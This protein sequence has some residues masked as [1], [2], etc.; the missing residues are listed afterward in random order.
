MIG[1]S[2]ILIAATGGAA[3]PILVAAG[4]GMGVVQAGGA[5]YKII[6]AKD[7]DDIEKA[8]YDVGA[9]TST[10]GLSLSGAK[11]SLKRASIE[12]EGLNA[13]SSAKKCITSIKDMSIEG[14]NVIKSGYYRATLRNPFRA[15]SEPAS[16]RKYSKELYKEGVKDAEILFKAIKDVLPEELQDSF[17]GRNKCQRSIYAKMVKER[18][19]MID[20]MIQKVKNNSAFSDAVKKAEIESL[21]ADR[22]RIKIDG[23]FAKSKVE[24]LFG[25]RL[26]LDDVSPA[27]MDKLVSSLCEAVKKGDIE[28]TEI[29]N[30]HGF[31]ENRKGL[32]DAYFSD[33]QIEKLQKASGG[34]DIIRNESKASGYT[35]VQLKVR[36]KNGKVVELQIRG[37]EVDRV[38]DLEHYPYDV[39][40]GKD[41]A[42]GNNKAGILLAKLRKAV[43]HL[44]QQDKDKYQEYFY[45]EYIYAQAKELGKPAIKPVLPEGLDPILSMENIEILYEQIKDFP[46]VSV[47]NPFLVSSV[48]PFVSGTEGLFNKKET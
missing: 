36:P 26:T 12:T 28:I 3:A 43:K 35:A 6:K 45:N 5:V 1:G 19:V 11:S 25:A 17:K 15:V 44:T 23:N 32:N 13:L 42:N 10:I 29:E 4:I 33:S 18:T 34:I 27:A 46:A 48:S 41:I 2:L 8:F 14:F 9:A 38:S 37:R 40:S 47:K 22:E 7:G 24:D 21:L 31:N 39:A 30:Y 20:K 16:L